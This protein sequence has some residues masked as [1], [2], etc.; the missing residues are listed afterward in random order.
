MITHIRKKPVIRLLDVLIS[1]VGLILLIPTFAVVAFAVKLQDGGPVF[2]RARRVG[3]DGREFGLYKFRTMIV[4]ADSI[5]AG[6]TARN[7]SRITSAGRFLRD[8]KLDELPQFFNVLVGDMSLV[9][10]RPED[11]RY[12]ALYSV[13]QRRVLDV[14]PGITSPASLAYKNEAELLSGEGWE[15]KYT[16]EVLPHKL[17]L[18]LEYLT[19]RSAWT[20]LKL[21][22]RTLGE[23]L[24]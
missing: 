21:I 22:F 5:G 8:W 11:P 2:Y 23:I 16:E 24:R 7:D 17:S 18:E 9:G 20:D 12:V 15:R 6:I 10:P 14:R 13:D 4:R 3:K 19:E 1:F